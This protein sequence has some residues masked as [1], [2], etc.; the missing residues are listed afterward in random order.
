MQTENAFCLENLSFAYDRGQPVLQGVDLTLPRGEITAI[1]GPNGCGKS[2]LFHLMCGGLKG[3]QGRIL[4]DG[5]DIWSIPRREFAREVAIVHQYNLAPDDITVRKLVAMGRTPYHSMF[6][7]QMTRE[8]HDAVSW[9]L[10][11]TDTEKFADR[12][13]QKLS[14]GQRQRVWLAL[15]LAQKTKVLLLDEITTYLDVFYQRQLL[16]MIAQLRQEYDLTVMMVLHDINQ[17]MEFCDHAVLLK[18]GQVLA[19]GDCEQVITPD[20]LLEAFHVNT[21]LHSIEDRPYCIFK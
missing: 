21:Q 7:S 15:A 14:G 9:A 6:S 11:V 5:R 8:D 16:G 17:A 4:L 20:N 13:I 2:T 1:L 10:E 19:A 12:P 18:H 3:Q